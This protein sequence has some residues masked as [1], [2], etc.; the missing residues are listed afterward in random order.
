M[1]EKE[2]G[3]ILLICEDLSN[4]SDRRYC[5]CSAVPS[6]EFRNVRLE[7]R[8][9]SLYRSQSLYVLLLTNQPTMSS[10][11]LRFLCSYVSYLKAV[12]QNCVT[13]SD[14]VIFSFKCVVMLGY[15]A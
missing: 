14:L 4:W 2:K 10:N 9:P 7:E 1:E 6:S 15:L 12:L 8:S 11:T 5:R 3:Q 13:V